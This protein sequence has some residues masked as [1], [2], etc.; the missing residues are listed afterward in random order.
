MSCSR[1]RA[2]PPI[3]MNGNVRSL[4][5]FCKVRRLTFNSPATSLSV[6]YRSPSSNGR[7][8][9]MK[10]LIFRLLSF[11]DTSASA[12]T[13]CSKVRISCFMVSPPAFQ[14]QDAPRPPSCNRISCQPANRRPGSCHASPAMSSD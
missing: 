5:I 10:R 9:C 14:T 2:F 1:Y 13:P 4:R 11:R 6:R 12:S 3:N 7:Y 8:S